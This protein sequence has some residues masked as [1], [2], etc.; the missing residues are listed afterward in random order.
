MT[1]LPAI[2]VIGLGP[3]GRSLASASLSAGHPT[4]L[5]NRSPAKAEALVARGAVLA[6]TAA[7]AAR[8]ASVTV[9]CVLDYAAA[10][11]VAADLADGTLVNLGSGHAAEARDMAAWAA[12]RGIDYSDG[13]ILTPAPA[14]GTPAAT[15]LYGGPGELPVLRAFGGT[16]TYLGTDPGLPAAYEMALLDLFVMSVGGLAHAFALAEAEGIAPA[17]F[18]PF[19][20]G[21]GALLP[22]LADRFAGDLTSGTFTAGIS[23]IASAA[24]A[25]A[26]VRAAATAR[27]VD[28]GPLRA[29]QA[30]IDGAVAAGHG[31]D[32]YARLARLLTPAPSGRQDR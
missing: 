20:T 25:V 9:L 7:E 13:A 11:A 23:S 27:G 22:G 32:S 17:T 18:A 2:A 28:T 16:S 1:R 12:G 29:V 31:G 30:I 8:S 21:I 5:W 10:R 3:M 19:A 4:V 6:A 15:I 24:S 26:H 14:I